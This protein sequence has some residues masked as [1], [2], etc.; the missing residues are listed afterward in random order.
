MACFY[1]EVYDL[2]PWLHDFTKLGMQTHFSTRRLGRLRRFLAFVRHSIT[3]A[4]R[5]AL[6]AAPPMTAQN[7]LRIET[8]VLPYIQHCLLEMPGPSPLHCA[9]LFCTDGYFTCMLANMRM[10]TLITGL[11]PCAEN[12]RRAGVASR[13]LHL[14][15]A[16]FI[17][18]KAGDFARTAPAYDLVLCIGGLAQQSAPFDFLQMLRTSG[19]QYLVLQSE[20]KPVPSDQDGLIHPSST[21]ACQ[22]HH[23]THTEL[24]EWLL[25]AGWQILESTVSA[26]GNSN[27]HADMSFGYYRCKAMA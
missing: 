2:R 14:K 6:L 18:A 22:P 5:L 16:H 27:G 23:F 3:G 19:S 26:L 10:S 25:K 11:D 13:L 1:P 21:L 24:A 4:S 17:Q 15:Q 9:D 8:R 7:Q 20:L 12:I